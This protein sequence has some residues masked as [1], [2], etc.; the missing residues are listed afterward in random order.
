MRNY[1]SRHGK[2]QN[3]E[4]KSFLKGSTKKRKQRKRSFMKETRK[5]EDKKERAG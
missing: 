4:H 5:Q 1:F 2:R 3:M